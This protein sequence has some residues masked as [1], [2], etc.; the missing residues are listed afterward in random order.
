VIP[1][2]RSYG[3]FLLVKI[4]SVT[5]NTTRLNNIIRNVD[6]DMADVVATI[7]FAVERVAKTMAPVETGALKASIYA[8]LKK[9]GHQPTQFDGVVYVDLPEPESELEAIVGPTVEYGIYLELG[10]SRQSAQPYLTPAVEQITNS[11]ERYRRDMRRALG[12]G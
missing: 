8:K 2:F 4:M 12:D 6:G 9:G 11:L 1:I 3:A 10:T 7:A 5:V